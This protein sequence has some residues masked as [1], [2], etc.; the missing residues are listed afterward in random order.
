MGRQAPGRLDR[1]LGDIYIYIVVRVGIS[2]CPRR[3]ES[4]QNQIRSRERQTELSGEKIAIS[5]LSCAS[6][7]AWTFQVIRGWRTAERLV[8]F[9]N[10]WPD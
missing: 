3:S 6:D 10:F 2:F 8:G 9:A 1:H 4:D 5:K 7:F